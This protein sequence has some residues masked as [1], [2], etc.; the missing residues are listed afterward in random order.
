MRKDTT[1]N[2]TVAAMLSAVAFILMFIEFPVPMLIPS[3]VKMDFSDLPALLGAF[4]LGPVYGVVISF[5]KNLLHIVVKGTS[6]AC[7]GEL[8]NFMLGAVFSAVAGFIYK[9][10]KSRK[11]AI[12]GAV[13]SVP[14]NYFITYPAYVEFYHMPLE[15]ILGMYQAILPSAD[16]LMKCLV[17]FNLPFTLVKGLLDAVLCMVIYKPL[18]PILHGRK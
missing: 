11:T 8:C 1:H 9:H 14:S 13:F 16:S 17:I 5:M 2:L 4:A 3:F 15:A 6:T 10:H 7:V 12:L 18:S